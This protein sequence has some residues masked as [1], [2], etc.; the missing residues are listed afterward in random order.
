MSSL[1]V[2]L[3]RVGRVWHYRFRLDGIRVQKS[4]RETDRTKAMAVAVDAFEAARKRARG[5]EPEPTLGDLVGLWLNAHTLCVSPSHARSVDR[6]GRLHLYGLRDLK[7]ADLSTKAVETAR[8]EYL[9]AHRKTS[10]NHWLTIL[11]LLIGWAIKRKMIRFVPWQVSTLHVQRKPKVV[12]SITKAWPWLQAVDRA[13]ERDLSMARAIRLMMGIGLRED[14]STRARWEWLDLERGVYTP[15][16]TKGREAKPRELPEWLM[17]YLRP[18]AKPY[19]W[20]AAAKNGRPVTPGRVRRVMDKASAELGIM[21]L[22]PHR[23]RGTYAT[24][25]SEEG[26]PIQDIQ[27]ALAH[28]SQKTTA[29]YLETDRARVRQAQKRIAQRLRG[30]GRESGEPKVV[31]G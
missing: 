13:S 2:S 26:V 7:L 27:E 25:L 16:E 31:N 28:K 17:D 12:L 29:D 8:L 18:I 11:R 9:A 23:L 19:G 21:G 15:G 3:F 1:R 6:F 14:E 24:W 30:H 4:T 10:A 22:T 5:E 20:V